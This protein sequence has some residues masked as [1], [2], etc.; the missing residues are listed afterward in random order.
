MLHPFYSNNSSQIILSRRLLI[1]GTP[2]EHD[3]IA[4]KLYHG[5]LFATLPLPR[6]YVSEC[7]E[8]LAFSV[9]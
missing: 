6:C 9:H 7:I 5:V 1:T 4:D 3:S 8:P 2:V